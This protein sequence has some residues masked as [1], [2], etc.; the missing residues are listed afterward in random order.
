LATDSEGEKPDTS[1]NRYTLTFA[2][3]ELPPVN[4]FW[5]V[6]MYDGKTQLLVA[7]SLKRYRLNSPMAPDLKES[8]DGS[9]TT[10]PRKPRQ[11]GNWKRIGCLRQTVRST[12]S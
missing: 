9:L 7:N 11:A 1:A 5:S 8:A 2:M 6:A 10:T 4:A 12:W 3:G